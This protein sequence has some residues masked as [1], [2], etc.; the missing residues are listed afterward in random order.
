MHSYVFNTNTSFTLDQNNFLRSD[1]KYVTKLLEV[2]LVSM[3]E[4][5]MTAT[6]RKHIQL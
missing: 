5:G 6:T 4:G 2:P 1:A 3:G